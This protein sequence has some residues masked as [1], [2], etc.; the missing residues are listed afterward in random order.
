[1]LSGT[2]RGVELLLNRNII[3]MQNGQ[4]PGASKMQLHYFIATEC[5][6]DV[7]KPKRFL[8]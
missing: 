1:M 5:G 4:T 2:E 8:L 3:S 6:C 7:D